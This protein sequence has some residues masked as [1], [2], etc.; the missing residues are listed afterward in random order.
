MIFQGAPAPTPRLWIRVC[1]LNVYPRSQLY[2]ISILWITFE[3][4]HFRV[5]CPDLGHL[6]VCCLRHKHKIVFQS[7]S[8]S[9]LGVF[10]IL[11]QQCN[12]L[13]LPRVVIP[14]FFFRKKGILI[15]CQSRSVVRPSVCPS[16]SPSVRTSVRHASCKCISS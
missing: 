10:F 1:L 9:V 11:L 16:V 8:L 7:G 14:A 2:L 6:S 13:N 5:V 4:R 12:H 3:G 15:S